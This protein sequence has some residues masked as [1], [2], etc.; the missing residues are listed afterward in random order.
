[1]H[2]NYLTY[3]NQKNIPE[4]PE[5]W[6][7]ETSRLVCF[8]TSN[9]NTELHPNLTLAVR[10]Y[11]EAMSTTLLHPFQLQHTFIDCE[12]TLYKGANTISLISQLEEA[13]EALRGGPAEPAEEAEPAP[14]DEAEKPSHKEEHASKKK[15]EKKE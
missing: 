9:W 1:M 6:N 12:D 4:E 11:L 2:T 14:A 5:F 3:L 15:K 13:I 10:P 8:E 7:E